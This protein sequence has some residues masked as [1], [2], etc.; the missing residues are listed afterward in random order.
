LK[1]KPQ[2]AIQKATEL[3]WLQG[4]QGTKMRDLQ[5][6]LDMRPG[7]I[8]AG[9]GSK[10]NLFKLAIA[11]YVSQSLAT[12]DAFNAD[13]CSPLDG[14]KAFVSNQIFVNGDMGNCRICLLVKT[15]SE[16]ENSHPELVLLAR[17]GLRAIENKFSELLLEAKNDYEISQDADCTRLGKWLQMQIMGLVVYTKGLAE[18]ADVKQMIDDIFASIK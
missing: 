5:M 4:F 7:S 8:Y 10:E 15:L 9:F 1:Y 16:S 2:E 18:P 6:K 3:F 17:N 11:R 12:I 14:L 13:A